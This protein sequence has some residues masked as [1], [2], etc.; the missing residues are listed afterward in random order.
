M[1]CIRAFRDLCRHN[2]AG[3]VTPAD[4]FPFRARVRLSWVPVTEIPEHLLKR[5]QAAKAKATGEAAPVEGAA[6]AVASSVPAVAEAAAPAAAA[7]AAPAKA[8]PAAPPPPKPDPPYVAAAK[9]RK[10][11]P[12]WAMGTLALLPIFIFMYWRGLTETEAVAAGPIAV[13]GELYTTAA[14]AG[15]HGADGGGG[16]GRQLSNG[17]V[18][19]TF[20]AIEDQLN[21][22]YVGTQGF[23][24]AG[25]PFY[26]DAERAHLRY[27]GAQM[28]A[29]K[30]ALSYL[31]IIEVS[32]YIRYELSGADPAGEY[33]EEHASWCTEEG[34]DFTRYATG[35]LTFGTDD[36]VGIEARPAG[37]ADAG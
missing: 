5:S 26:G 21:F 2:R 30:D 17:E 36:R 12:Y 24:D 27:N 8:A 28:P 22:I 33:A 32:C 14:C 19:A 16:V 13:G 25:L 37:G 10:K 15:C 4:R 18:L 31:E 6:P 9:S 1:L 23:E 35:E 3:P 7:K 20:P 34:E 11:I 29:Q